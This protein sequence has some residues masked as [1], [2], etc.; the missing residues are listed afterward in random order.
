M[1]DLGWWIGRKGIA[2]GPHGLLLA[3]WVSVEKP[4]CTEQACTRSADLLNGVQ[5]VVLT[6]SDAKFT[7]K[8]EQ[9]MHLFTGEICGPAGVFAKA[10]ASSV[11]NKRIWIVHGAIGV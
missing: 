10:Q 8:P 7:K 4:K 1:W 6:C 5:K 3:E 2:Y 9:A 11:E